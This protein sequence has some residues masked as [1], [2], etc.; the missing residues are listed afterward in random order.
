MQTEPTH[1]II[2]LIP[3]RMTS[4]RIVTTFPV[5]TQPEHK[6]NKHII[7][8]ILTFTSEMYPFSDFCV[9]SFGFGNFDQ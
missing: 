6:Q 3:G 9:F 5:H 1:L 4:E 8:I 2:F 7:S